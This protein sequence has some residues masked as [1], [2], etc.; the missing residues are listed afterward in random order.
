MS[1]LTTKLTAVYNR[2]NFNCGNETLNIYLKTQVNQDIKKKLTACFVLADETNNVIGYYTLSSLSI[3]ID[4][5]PSDIQKK[6]PKGY[7]DLPVTLL[8][9]LAIDSTRKGQNYGEL[10]LLDALKRSYE[11][12]KEIASMAIVV[13]PID[14]IAISFYTKYGFII[15]DSGKM[16]ISMKTIEQFFK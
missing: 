11:I 4:I 13:D 5:T 10:L 1:Y 2:N 16:F 7:R 9:R 8:G 14:V 6:I 3:S 15:L 12:S